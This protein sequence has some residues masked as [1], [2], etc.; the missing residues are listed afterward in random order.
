MSD[1]MEAFRRDSQQGDAP[2]AETTPVA[3]PLVATSAP[4]PAPASS[5][6]EATPAPAEV[7]E[8]ST[9]LPPI[10]FTLSPEDAASTQ[11]MMYGPLPAP[12]ANQQPAA[13]VVQTRSAARTRTAT[14]K[15]TTT[16]KR[17]A[18]TTAAT[19]TPATPTPTPAAATTPATPATAGSV[20]FSTPA[21]PATAPTTPTPVAQPQKS[22]AWQHPA[23]AAACGIGGSLIAWQ[24]VSFVK[25]ASWWELG[26]V[27]IWIVAVVAIGWMIYKTYKTWEWRP[28]LTAAV[29]IIAIL[30]ANHYW[31]EGATAPTTSAAAGTP[32]SASPAAVTP[33]AP[34][35]TTPASTTPKVTII[36]A[37]DGPKNIIAQVGKWSETFVFEGGGNADY[38]ALNPNGHY[39]LKDQRGNEYTFSPTH[40]D[41]VPPG[42][43]EASF[44][45]LGTNPED[46]RLAVYR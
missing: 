27:A 25:E 44:M 42:L 17:A 7:V 20:L 22:K 31:P 39:K 28:A 4:A 29:I 46:I 36:R 32:V 9:A 8:E 24:L 16:R 23:F 35:A 10:E 40:S 33:T 13:Q 2:P 26:L 41:I 6:P 5:E 34:A 19:T 38:R 43:I 11:S 30:I 37:S 3:P 1:M 12:A 45:A 18:R 15:R 21:V 14:R